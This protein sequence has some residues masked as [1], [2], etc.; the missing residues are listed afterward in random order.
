VCRGSLGISTGNIGAEVN[1]LKAENSLKNIIIIFIIYAMNC[2]HFLFLFSCGPRCPWN[3][4]A[5][6]GSG[7]AVLRVIMNRTGPGETKKLSNLTILRFYC[8]DDVCIRYPVYISDDVTLRHYAQCRISKC[9][10]TGP[11]FSGGPIFQLHMSDISILQVRLTYNVS[12]LYYNLL[13]DNLL[14]K[15]KVG[16]IELC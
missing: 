7:T 13:Q 15:S 10:G 16:Q 6:H 14:F 3:G 9:G 8:M 1:L 12:L 4:L 2:K 11:F 5:V